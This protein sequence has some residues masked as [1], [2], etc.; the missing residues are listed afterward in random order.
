[1][2]LVTS[3]LLL[4]LT[5]PAAA[6]YKI[7]TRVSSGKN[8][9][10]SV[11]LVQGA[12]Q[13]AQLGDG[14]IGIFQCDRHQVVQLN[15]QTKLYRITK[16]D[17]EGFPLARPAG[18]NSSRHWKATTVELKDRAT[19]FGRPAWHV[20]DVI[21]EPETGFQTKIDSWY[22]DVP[23]ADGCVSP[24]R[25]PS[26]LDQTTGIE[27]SGEARRGF[28]VLMRRTTFT[29]PT[30]G[31]WVT[32]VKNSRRHSSIPPSSRSRL[33]TAKLSTL[34]SRSQT[35]PR[36]APSGPGTTCGPRSPVS[37]TTSDQ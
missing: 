15:P 10:T 30:Q 17:A 14:N 26:P 8:G 6:D 18:V 35:Q 32:E 3:A 33:T 27:R 25:P 9:F 31:E 29:T 13:R 21:H 11:R 34:P 19:I 1:M 24:S 12:R 23:I 4:L 20:Q 2:R 16:L 37:S 5:L 7:V 36:T 22:I 28:A